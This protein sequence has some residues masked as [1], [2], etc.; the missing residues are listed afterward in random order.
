MQLQRINLSLRMGN[1]LAPFIFSLTN[2][3]ILPLRRVLPAIGR[4]GHRLLGGRLCR[5]VGQSGVAVV[6]GG[7]FSA[8]FDVAGVGICRVVALGFVGL[9]LVGHWLRFVVMVQRRC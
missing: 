8:R 7:R 6:V 3:L 2:W 9:V 4:F 1:P 5:G